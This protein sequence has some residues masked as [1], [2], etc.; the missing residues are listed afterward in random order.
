[1]FIFEMVELLP[2]KLKH[3]VMKATNMF[4]TSPTAM[5]SN[6]LLIQKSRVLLKQFRR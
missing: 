4:L 3:T 5:K 1:M 6:F 2:F